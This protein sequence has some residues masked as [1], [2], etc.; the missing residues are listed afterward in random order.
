MVTDSWVVVAD[1]TSAEGMCGSKAVE[2]VGR[3]VGEPSQGVPF[4]SIS[5]DVL[6][7][8]SPSL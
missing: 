1:P 3:V 2:E 5:S 7:A 4:A 8:G 6:E